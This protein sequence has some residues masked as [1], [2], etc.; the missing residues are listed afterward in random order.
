MREQ[1]EAFGFGQDVFD[2]LPGSA[3]SVFPD[4]PDDPQTALSAIGQFEV[5]ATPLQMAMVVAGI[6]NEGTVMQPYLVAE[7]RS[8]DLDTLEETEPEALSQ[9]VSSGV[10][11]DLR[12]MMVEVTQSGT[13]TSAAIPDMEVGSKTG[14][15]E[16]GGGRPPYAWFVSFAPADDPEVAVAVFVEDANVPLSEISGGGLAG[17]IAKSV[18]EAVIGQ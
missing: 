9:A 18:M 12:E 15:A 10:A 3:A 7:E 11:A 6:A 16:S 17:P 8:P 5:A 1:A 2:D 4:N 13:G 14:T